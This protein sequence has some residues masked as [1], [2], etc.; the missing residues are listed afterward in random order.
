M[1]NKDGV[2]NN[3]DKQR[4]LAWLNSKSKGNPCPVCGGKKLG[5]ADHLIAGMIFHNKG[6]TVDGPGY[7][8]LLITCQDCHNATWFAAKPILGLQ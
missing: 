4:A 6:V 8:M 1:P 2:L 5:I 7:P 3:A